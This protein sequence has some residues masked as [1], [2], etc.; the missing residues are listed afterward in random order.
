MDLNGSIITLRVDAS[1][2]F[3]STGGIM[4]KLILAAFAIAAFSVLA[5]AQSAQPELIVKGRVLDAGGN[6]VVG[7]QVT[8]G[9]PRPLKGVTPRGR[10]DERGEFSVVVHQ[11]GEFF[12]AA[13]KP[14]ERH[15]S[16]ANRFYY[17][18]VAKAALV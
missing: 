15:Q 17:P 13:T 6:P 1:D 5:T 7:A 11:T 10:S 4:S 8:P 14:V 16:T 18:F 9:P 12:V 3:N 2:P